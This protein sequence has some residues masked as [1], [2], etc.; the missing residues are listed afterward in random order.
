MGVKTAEVSQVEKDSHKIG[1]H[2]NQMQKEKNLSL[3]VDIVPVFDLLIQLNLT[4]KAN[5]AGTLYLQFACALLLLFV[6]RVPPK[7]F[8]GE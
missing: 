3:E 2:N 7:R 8:F 5:T 6:L 4:T 1:L